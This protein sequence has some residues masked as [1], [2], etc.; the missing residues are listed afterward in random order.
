MHSDTPDGQ[1]PKKRRRQWHIGA[2]ITVDRRNGARPR[3]RVM[4]VVLT[5]VSAIAVG[6]GVG[7]VLM[8]VDA[9]LAAGVVGT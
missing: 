2:D 7:I 8:V 6:A 5:V 3:G 4:V 1:G 9:L